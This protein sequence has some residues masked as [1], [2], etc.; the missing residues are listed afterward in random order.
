VSSFAEVRSAGSRKLGVVAFAFAAVSLA[1][2]PTRALA[3]DDACVPACRSSYLCLEGRC[4]SACNPSCGVAETC[5]AA[6]ECV[7]AAPAAPPPRATFVDS[8]P[9][10]ATTSGLDVD[11]GWARGAFY[12]GATSVALDVALTAAIVAA[13]P[14]KAD[15]ARNLGGLSVVV[16]GVTAPIT[17]LGAASARTQAAVTGHPRL[18]VASWVGYALTLGEVAWL[19]QRSY[20]KVIGDGWVVSV[21]VLG[22]LTT[23]G[24]TLDARASADQAEHLRALGASRPVIGFASGGGGARVPTVPTLGWAGT[25]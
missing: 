8:S 2:G 15:L 10:T 17:T 3:G 21:G 11:A 16:F 12:F 20:D 1:A 7:P 14:A 22:T 4:V 6:G 25:F 5:T 18:R 9:P 19:L 13:N 23:L 24:F